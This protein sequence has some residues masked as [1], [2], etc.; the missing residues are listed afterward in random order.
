MGAPA[1][2]GRAPEFVAPPATS[3]AAAPAVSPPSAAE[4]PPWPTIAFAAVRAVRPVC[5]LV[6]LRGRVVLHIALSVI[7]V[8]DAPG[9]QLLPHD[10]LGLV[11][12]H[13]HLGGD[14]AHNLVAPRVHPAAIVHAETIAQDLHHIVLLMLGHSVLLFRARR[15]AAS[16]PATL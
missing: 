4:G 8:A 12:V 13:M 6:V 9:V 16:S 1:A 10:L 15:R 11:V 5:A 14:H 3:G 2:S 7:D